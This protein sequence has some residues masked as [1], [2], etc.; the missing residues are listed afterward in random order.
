MMRNKLLVLSLFAAFF[1]IAT[2]GCKPDVDVESTCKDIAQ[3]TMIGTDSVFAGFFVEDGNVLHIIE[4]H[5]LSGETATR[6]E[7]LFGDGVY[8]PA[9]TVEYTYVMGDYNE[10]NVGVKINFTPK[11]NS[12]QPIEALFF[13]GTFTE[14]DRVLTLKTGRVAALQELMGTLPNTAWEY[15]DTTLLVLVDTITFMDTVINKKVTPGGVIRDTVITKK[16]KELKDTIGYKTI[17]DISFALN[18][19]AQTLAN[20]GKYDYN[21]VLNVPNADS[22]DVVKADTACVEKHYQLLHWGLSDLTTSQKFAVAAQTDNA[23][24]SVITFTFGK[25]RPDKGTTEVDK[26]AYTLIIP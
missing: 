14:G 13:E 17:L 11:D 22:T 6:T 16:T 25:F 18:R 7:M 15:H 10:A 8:V 23:N 2:V 12:A 21:Y 4:Y 1:A 19:D 9:N 24:D 20:T 5:F 3:S 26:N